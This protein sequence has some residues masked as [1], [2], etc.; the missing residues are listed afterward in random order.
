MRFDFAKAADL[1]LNRRHSRL[2]WSEDERAD[3]VGKIRKSEASGVFDRLIELARVDAAGI[4]APGVEEA[5]LERGAK[6]VSHMAMPWRLDRLAV[7]AW[8]VPEDGQLSQAAIALAGWMV[9]ASSGPSQRPYIDGGSHGLALTYDLL[10]WRFSDEQRTGMRDW[11]I[12]YGV[13][14]P[15]EKVKKGFLRGPGSNIALVGVFQAVV[16]LLAVYGDDSATDLSSERE[17]LIRFLD[18]GAQATTGPE[19]YPAEDIGYGT[20]VAAE[21]FVV[22]SLAQRAGWFHLGEMCP[23]YYK[24]GRA[25]LH[26]VQPW[27]EYLT[28][29]GDHGDD[30]GLREFILPIT[31]AKTNDPSLLW[32]MGSIFYPPY[33]YQWVGRDKEFPETKLADGRNM[34]ISWMTLAAVEYLSKPVPPAELKIPTQYKDESRG[35]V[36]FRSSWKDDATYLYFDGGERPTTALGHEHDSAGHFGLTALGEY[37]GISPGRYNMDQTCHSLMLVDGKTGHDIGGE[38]RATRYRGRLTGYEPGGFVDAA[39]GDN[40]QQSNCYWSYRT[41]GLVKGEGAPAYAWTLDDVNADHGAIMPRDY[42]WTL[43][44]SPG[45]TIQT[46]ERGAT[47]TGVRHGNRLEVFFA[48]PDSETLPAP[49]VV[50]VE[51]DEITPSSYRYV[52]TDWMEKERRNYVKEPWDQVHGP[53]FFRPRLVAKASGP[54]GRMLSLMVPTLKDGAAPVFKRLPNLDGQVGVEINFGAVTDTILC[55]YGHRQ[56]VSGDIDAR[57]NWLVIRRETATGRVVNHRL[58]GGSYLKVGGKRVV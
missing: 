20:G 42:W 5:F 1:Y 51:Q 19:G 40:A 21:M 11:L 12:Q 32:L 52:G 6:A 33:K 45:N 7:A 47:I 16:N 22:A 34:P 39:S 57:G 48:T 50:R 15:L 8:L 2:I 13:R 49:Y 14:G 53:V 46:R 38:W 23:Q 58:M 24:F 55:A 18:A 17:T 44:T 31:A 3:V 27:G 35:I 28:N 36:S 43:H 26:F 25:I 30:F 9:K 37:F 56:L 41:I 4:L 29:T 10:H 54:N